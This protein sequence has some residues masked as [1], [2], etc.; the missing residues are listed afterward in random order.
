MLE[1]NNLSYSYQN[2]EV[3]AVD[4]ISFSFPSSGLFYIVGES[5]SGKSTFMKVLS[6]LNT[7]YQGSYTYRGKEVNRLSLKQREDLLLNEISFCS[8]ED[9]FDSEETALSSIQMGLE[10]YSL[11]RAEKLNRINQYAH[12]VSIES[13]LNKKNKQLSGGELKRVA[14]VRSLVKDY[15]CLLL[16]EPLGPLDKLTRKKLTSLFKDISKNKLVIIISHSVREIEKKDNIL[17][18]KDGKMFSKKRSDKED[19]FIDGELVKRRPLSVLS[20]IRRCFSSL[21]CHKRRLFSSL[22][23]SSLAFISLGLISLISSSISSGLK[24][25]L[26][27]EEGKNTMLIQ[28]REKELTAS[29]PTPVSYQVCLDALN[30]YPNFVYGIGAYYKLNFEDLFQSGNRVFVEV[31]DKELTF[32]SLSGRNFEEFTYSIELAS[33]DA[34]EDVVLD[35]HSIGLGLSPFDA[36]ALINFLSIKTDDNI[37]SLNEY[38]SNCGLSINLSLR[39]NTFHYY[40]EDSF[41]VEKIISTSNSQ[42]IHN[43]PSFG[44]TFVEEGMKFVPTDSESG[45]YPNPWTIYKNFFLFLKPDCKS[46]FLE[47]ITRDSKY[48]TY[49]IKS[50]KEEWEVNDSETTFKNRVKIKNKASTCISYSDIYQIENRYKSYIEATYLSDNFYYCNSN[51][52]GSGFLR[53]VYVSSKRELL[54]K[55]SDYNYEASFDLE[56]FQ[57]ASIQYEEGVVKGD[58]SQT[59]DSPLFFQPYIDDLDILKGKNPSNY[60]EVAISSKLAEY[61]YS[62]VS[63]SL[64]QTLFITCL[65]ETI[66]KDGGY[67]NIFTDGEVKVVG[68]VKNDDDNLIYQKP[69]FL[70]TLQLEQLGFEEENAYISH[71][72]ITFKPG[73]D[74]SNVVES[75]KNQYCQYKFSF[76][77]KEMCES[78]DMIIS[79]IGNGLLA[80]GLFSGAIACCLIC[81]VMILFINEGQKRILMMKKLGFTSKDIQNYYLGMN[82][83]LTISSVV[84]SIGFLAFFSRFFSFSLSNI[85][86]VEFSSSSPKMYTSVILAGS[87][88]ALISSFITIIKLKKKNGYAY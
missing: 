9:L 50:M 76:P 64:N 77:S 24:N 14:L 37:T 53:P 73:Y 10:I 87:V 19:P 16:D 3:K 41:T 38:I 28:Y 85:L 75:L 17:T 84:S 71:A 12:L 88:L 13:L 30:D 69:R 47:L 78:I 31:L 18:F 39:N 62:T 20:I 36:Q 40:L 80:F 33:D 32:N 82:M 22:S 27:G 66:R 60:Q 35:E 54:N 4:D 2:S 1:I 58:L 23:A 45:P 44:E 59:S 15:S 72:L 42:I 81:L 86:G 48:S 57:G 7:D 67:K 65:K 79:Y 21:W 61:L 83:L 51:I 43:D 56:G 25:Y 11:P 52:S 70:Q 8:Q 74:V 29:S 6:G 55:I 68:V 5:G 49:V 34:F 63:K 46:E 26:S